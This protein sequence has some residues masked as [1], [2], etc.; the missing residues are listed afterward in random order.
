MEVRYS[1]KQL[2]SM[3]L[4]Q[5][6]L[7]DS[8]SEEIQCDIKFFIVDFEEHSNPNSMFVVLPARWSWPLSGYWGSLLLLFP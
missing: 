1:T 6:K 2:S 4:N 5:A 7:N 3:Q 8:D